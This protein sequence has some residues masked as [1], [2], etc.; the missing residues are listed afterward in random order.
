MTEN[1][2]TQDWREIVVMVAQNAMNAKSPRVQDYWLNM[3]RVVNDAARRHE[4]GTLKATPTGRLSDPGP[5]MQNI[6]IRTEEGRAIREAFTSPKLA[7]CNI[8]AR[9]YGQKHCLTCS[10][11]WDADDDKPKCEGEE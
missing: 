11:F 5:N 1:L 8:R 9:G 6:P 2:T 4:E 7:R 3:Q 10:R